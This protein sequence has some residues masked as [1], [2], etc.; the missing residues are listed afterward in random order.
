ML[1]DCRLIL[2]LSVSLCRSPVGSL[3]FADARDRTWAC[4]AK[5]FRSTKG[6]ADSSV[7]V[8]HKSEVVENKSVVEVVEVV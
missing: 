2:L 7:V 8:A 6:A 4:L 5:D 3:G 1:L